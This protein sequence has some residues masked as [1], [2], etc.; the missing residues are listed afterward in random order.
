MKINKEGFTNQL[1]NSSSYI[2]DNAVKVPGLFIFSEADVAS[3][4]KMN[5]QVYTKWIARGEPVSLAWL[6]ISCGYEFSKLSN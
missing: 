5:K 4:P 3:P 2:H 6:F 1:K